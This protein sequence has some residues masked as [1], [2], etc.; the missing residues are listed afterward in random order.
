MMGNLIINITDVANIPI[1]V[2]RVI[3]Y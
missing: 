2:I 3:T 1:R